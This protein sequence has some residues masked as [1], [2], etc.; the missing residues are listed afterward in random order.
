L[1]CQPPTLGD[2]LFLLGFLS[3][4]LL[5][6]LGWSEGS[7]LFELPADNPLRTH[8]LVAAALI[9]IGLAMAVVPRMFAGPRGVLPWMGGLTLGLAACGLL[10]PISA[11]SASGPGAWIL[12]AILPLLIFEGRSQDSGAKEQPDPLPTL[13]ESLPVALG[14]VGL[15]LA[16]TAIATPITRMLPPDGADQAIMV[17]TF[18]GLT[19]L[20]LW[21]LGSWLGK[22]EE[23]REASRLLICLC[24]GGMVCALSLRSTAS[25]TR[26]SGL[27]EVVG[28]VGLDVADAGTWAFDLLITVVALG[29]LA[30]LSGSLLHLAHQGRMFLALLAGTGIGI[31]VEPLISEA[32]THPDAAFA[33]SWPT[34][35]VAGG[36]CMALVGAIWRPQNSTILAAIFGCLALWWFA[37][38]PAP[39]LK[40]WVRF[41]TQPEW[42][43]EHSVGE[44]ALTPGHGGNPRVTLDQRALTGANVRAGIDAKIL[45]R[46]AKDLTFAAETPSAL[47]VGQLDLPRSLGL[48]DLGFERADRTAFFHAAMPRLEKELFD[49]APAGRVPG[50]ILAPGD[51][52]KRLQ[53]G[54]YDLVLV[55]AI[56]ER[57]PN[58]P[59]LTDLPPRTRVMAWLDGGAAVAR[60]RLPK[61]ILLVADGVFDLCVG[62]QLAGA[63][64]DEDWFTPGPA[65]QEPIALK[66]LSKRPAA[67]PNLYR[68]LLLERCA[69]GEETSDAIQPRADFL[70]AL[71]AILR[72]QKPS[73]PFESR[74]EA[75]EINN[76]Q[77]TDLAATV[78]AGAS[79]RFVEETVFGIARVLVKKRRVEA[80]QEYLAPISTTWGRPLELELALAAAD[81]ESLD[82][83]SALK[84]LQGFV[85]S[86]PRLESLQEAAKAL[87]G[88]QEG[89]DGD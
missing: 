1:A 10:Q 9:V 19:T 21:L 54:A 36:I 7:H 3:A 62:V 72:A 32:C 88:A 48:I 89:P 53:D 63:D 87:L 11:D 2:V 23:E 73:S 60:M 31:A 61:R 12:L 5:W 6:G 17:V 76:K 41:A 57:T 35:A 56:P 68:A 16:L 13:G 86:D 82:A 64:R 37:P 25:L 46:S 83:Q 58:L 66:R 4:W 33:S 49:Q 51:A 34:I 69:T 67:W 29:P 44:I 81:I 79:G 24:L 14:G 80:I 50:E 75:F 40:A 26:P 65:A 47:L 15:G 42:V 70:R 39:V 59:L 22:Q 78:Q 85:T 20:S 77:M 84:H 30:L 38:G 55:P 45:A 52:W 8:T 18:L 74:A 28:L 43:V 71:A 27:R